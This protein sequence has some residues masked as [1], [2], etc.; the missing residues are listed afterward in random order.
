MCERGILLV[1]RLG[2]AYIEDITWP[3]GDANFKLTRERYFQH[4][5]LMKFLHK[6][7]FFFIHFR[8]SKIVPLKWSPIANA[9]HKN[10][11]ILGYKVIKERER[12]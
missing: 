6:T 11:M 12:Q 3:R 9:C 8:N 7:K 2:V 1:G 10:V 5:I 4:E